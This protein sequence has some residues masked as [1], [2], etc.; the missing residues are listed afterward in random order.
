M[1]S[2]LPRFLAAL[3][4]F[5]SAA[6]YL[7]AHS[8]NEVFPPHQPIASFPAQLGPWNGT[9]LIIDQETRDVLGPGE[10]LS[11]DYTAGADHGPSIDLLIAYFPSQST[12]DTIH[13]PMHCLP[14]SGWLP[15]DTA[16]VT[17]AVPGH[18][19]FPANRVVVARGGVRNLVLYWYWAHDRG[20]A[21]EY[22]AKYYLVKDSI[23][24][25]RSD[26]ALVRII[27]PMY[28][29]ESAPAAY[30]RILPFAGE[31]VPRL[32]NYIPR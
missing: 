31:I 7:R 12:G 28:P 10:F 20:V 19:P 1:T 4:L 18:D 21:S 22:W 2:S 3:L 26:G 8:R 11:R 23:Q 29:G 24:M 14:G 6:V 27:T 15:I 9:D 13:S 25:H 16:R 32:N 30:Q 17:V 5:A